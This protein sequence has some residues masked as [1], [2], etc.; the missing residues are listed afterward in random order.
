M[1]LLVRETRCDVD[2]IRHFGAIAVARSDRVDA[3]GDIEV[4]L[5]L[6]ST[7]KPFLLAALLDGPLAEEEFSDPELALMSSSHNGEPPHVGTLLQLL[8]RFDIQPELLSCGMHDKWREWANPSPL[9]NNCSGK[10]AAFLIAAR[11]CGERLDDYANKDAAS[12]KLA[13]SGMAKFFGTA[14]HSVGVD[15]CSIPTCAYSMAAIASAARGYALDTLGPSLARVRQAHLRAPFYV[16]GTDRLESYL[17]GRHK[18][19]AKSGS[20]GLWMIGVPALGVGL[21]GKV[22]SG[23]EA[24]VQAALLRVLNDLGAVSI[25]ADPYLATYYTRGRFCLTGAQVGNIEACF[26]APLSH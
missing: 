1:M 17:I 16:G 3:V 15:G 13:I 9:G 5:P 25:A 22:W 11:I 20:D 19:A 10:H 24:A 12:Q 14:P 26:P 4:A 21:A 6:R 8:S 23:V 18:L 7:G 2:E